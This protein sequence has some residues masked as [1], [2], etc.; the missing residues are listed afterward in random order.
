MRKVFAWEASFLRRKGFS[1]RE[2]GEFLKIPEGTVCRMIKKYQE[3]P[4]YSERIGSKRNKKANPIWEH[5]D[6][7]WVFS[8]IKNLS[9]ST[10]PEDRNKAL[11]L[12]DY[13]L[14]FLLTLDITKVKNKKSYLFKAL[15][16]KKNDF[17]KS[18]Y[19]KSVWVSLE[20]ANLEEK[21]SRKTV[22]FNF[23]KYK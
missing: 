7:D 17:L 11:Q 3:N 16:R 15:L 18:A 21:P 5:I 20:D 6:P 1:Y 9:Y 8:F 13:L 12:T 2:I 19:V 4:Y 10:F 14:D 23:D 22:M